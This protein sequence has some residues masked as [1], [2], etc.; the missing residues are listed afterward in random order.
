MTTFNLSEQRHKVTLIGWFPNIF[1]LRIAKGKLALCWLPFLGVSKHLYNSLRWLV[2]WLVHWSV[3][4]LVLPGKSRAWFVIQLV[5]TPMLYS[6]DLVL[7]KLKEPLDFVL[8]T[9]YFV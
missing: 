8:I 7:T 9:R 2:C 5:F 4:I 6:L 3:P 1:Y